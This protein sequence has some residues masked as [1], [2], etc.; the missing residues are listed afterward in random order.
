MINLPENAVKY[1]KAQR[2]SL[3]V[4]KLATDKQRIEKWEQSCNEE[5]KWILENMDVGGRLLDI[6]CGLGGVDVLL[7]PCVDHIYLLDGTGWDDRRAGFQ[8][9]TT[10]WNSLNT[11][12]E[13]MELNGIT[14]KTT[15]FDYR[16][17][18]E[19]EVDAV[20]SITSWCYHYPADEYLEWVS[21]ILVRGGQC[22]VDMRFS[23]QFFEEYN[24][25]IAA[26]FIPTDSRQL[27]KWAGR[28]KGMRFV[29]TKE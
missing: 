25:F 24:K 2:G 23:D 16:D 11:T 6:G 13:V 27:I 28:W 4:G 22:C 19:I 9:T 17:R 29:L 15:L 14:D 1:I 26:G 8:E 12:R 21:S 3:D 18:P 20:I 5:V 10:P 7:S